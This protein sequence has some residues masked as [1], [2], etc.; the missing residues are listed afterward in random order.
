[1]STAADAPRLRPRG[2][3][4]GAVAA[5]FLAQVALIFWFNNRPPSRPRTASAAPV[6]RLAAA[7]SSELLEL[8]DPALFGLPHQQG[9]S[10]PAWLRIKR[11]P[12]QGFKWSEPT[13]SPLPLPAPALGGAFAEFMATNHFISAELPFK[14][15]PAL[16]KA[17]APP[18]AVPGESTLRLEGGLAEWRLRTALALPSWPPHT[19]SAQELDLVTKSV[20]QVVVDAKGKPVSVTLLSSSSL[21]AADQFALEQARLSRFD[22]VEQASPRSPSAF[23]GLAWGRMVFEWHTVPQPTP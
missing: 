17:E 10:G 15:E 19:N 1:M 16:G 22:P 8:T 6:L 2:R 18:L 9:F 20:V 11:E 13:N 23:P 14:P 3:W 12:L 7:P 21:P 4:L 5:V